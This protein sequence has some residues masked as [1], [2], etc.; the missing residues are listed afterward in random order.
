MIRH[1]EASAILS[2]GKARSRSF[3]RAISCHRTATALMGG[4]A[5]TILL[6]VPAAAQTTHGGRGGQGNAPGSPAG[7]ISS[8]TGAGSTGGNAAENYEGAGGG[9]AGVTGGAG[10]N[11]FNGTLGGAGG[12]TAGA[13]GS[14][15]VGGGIGSRASG[16][17]GGAHGAVLSGAPGTAVT[18][19]NGG[20]GGYG[21]F[22]G[23]SGGDGGIGLLLTGTGTTASISGAVTGGNGGAGGI[24]VASGCCSNGDNGAGGIGLIGSGVAIVLHATITGGLNGNGVTRAAAM[25]LSGTNQIALASGWGL[26]GG[27]ELA[28]GS[29]EFVQGNNQTLSNDIFGSGQLIKSSIGNLTLSGN[30]SYAG[31]T[32]IRGG[33]LTM[34]SANALG[35]GD[36]LLSGGTLDLFAYDLAAGRVSGSGTITSS[37]G[38]TLTQTSG[39]GI[40]GSFG[41][42]IV[43]AVGI[44]VD[45]GATLTLRGNNNL[46]GGIVLAG[47]LVIDQT[48]A[49]GGSGN[50]ITTVGSVIS[51]ANGVDNTANIQIASD[52]TVLDV[53]GGD[54]ATQSGVISEDQPGRGFEKSGAGILI[55]SATNSYTGTTLVSGGVLGLAANGAA[56][57]GRIDL[58]NGTTLYNANPCGCATTIGNDIAIALG[59]TAAIATFGNPTLLSGTLSGGNLLFA[60]N[61]GAS[62][63]T[64]TGSNSYGATGIDQFIQLQVGDGGTAGTLGTGAVTVDGGLIFSRSDIVTV[65]NDIGGIG[66]LTQDGSGTLILTGSNNYSGGTTI[67]QG[68]LQVGAGGTIGTLGTG[69]IDNSGSLVFNRSDDLAVADYITG[70]GSITKLGAGTL[71]LSGTNDYTGITSILAGTLAITGDALGDSATV[72]IDN[73]AGITLLADSN[74]SHDMTILSGGGTID[75]DAYTFTVSGAVDFQGELTKLGAGTLTLRDENDAGTGAGGINV[76]AGTLALGSDTAAGTGTIKLADSTILLNASCGCNPLTVSNAIQIALGGTAT[77]DAD[78]YETVLSGSLTGG[79]LI[80]ADTFGGGTTTLTGTNSYGD[81]TVQANATLVIGDG[82]TTGTLGTGTVTTDGMLAFDRSDDITLSNAIG[83]SGLLGQFGTGK[84]ILT[85]T[86]TYSGG[87]LIL[88]PAGTIQVGDGGTSGALGTGQISMAGTLIFNRSDDI[89]IADDI[90]GDGTITKLGAGTLTLSGDNSSYAGLV[91][92]LAGTVATTQTGLGFGSIEIDNGAQLKALDDVNALNLTVLSGGA[93]IDT[94][95]HF[96]ALLGDLDFQGAFTKTGSGMLVLVNAFGSSTGSG[97]I[98]VDQGTLALVSDGAAG[99]GIIKLANGTTLQNASCG[100][101]DLNVDNA[102]QIALGGTATIDGADANVNLNGAIS[103]GD[104]HFINSVSTPAF[105]SAFQLNGTNSYGR[106]LIGP[107][108]AVI[109]YDGTLGA[110]DVVF[111]AAPSDPA[112][113]AALVFQNATDYSYAGKIIGSGIVSV[114]ADAGNSVTLT[115]SN[116]GSAN[117]TGSVE[118]MSGRL[119]INGDF[120]DVV[121]NT[122]TLLLEDSCFCGGPTAVLGGSGTFHG[123]VTM[124]EAVLAPGNSP[125]TLVIAG[126]LTLGS[127]TIL[128]YE[129]GEPGTPGGA[130]NDLVTVGGNLTLNG[131]LNTI[132]SGAGYGPGYYR[133]FNYGGTLTDNEIVIGSIAGGL[134]AQILT[135][136]GGQVNVR[137]GGAS[138]LQYWDGTDMGT[139]TGVTGGSG[140]WKGSNTN[141]T[142]PTGYAINDSWEGQTAVFAGAAGGTVTVFGT[143]NFEELRFETDGYVLSPFDSSARLNTTGGFSIIDVASGITADIGV[144]IQGGAGIDKTGTGT[145]ILSAA[146]AYSGATD[147]A[148]GTLRLGINNALTDPT[149]LTVWSGATLDLNGFTTHVGSLAGTGAV[150]LGNGR[151]DVGYNNSSTIFGGTVTGADGGTS[152]FTKNGSGT[153]TVDGTISLGNGGGVLSSFFQVNAGTLQVSGTGSL[154][155]DLIQNFSTIENSGTINA[156]SNFQTFSTVTNTATGVIT[157]NVQNFSTFDN[158]GTMDGLQS[159]GGTATNYATGVINGNVQTFA[160]FTSAGVINGSISNF[161]TALIENQVNGEIGNFQ[162]GATVTLTGTTTGITNYQ[163]TQDTLFDLAGFDTTIGAL[164]GGGSVQMGVATL[165]IDS[166][167]L[168]SSFGGTISGSGGLI[169]TG[170]GE[171]TLAGLNTYTGDTAVNAGTLTLDATGGLTSDVIVASGAT[172][173]DN[174]AVAG[175]VTNNGLLNLGGSS[176]VT[177]GL[178]WALSNNSGGVAHAAGTIDAGIQNAGSFVIDGAFTGVTRFDQSASGQLSLNYDFGVEA[179]T[180]S[181]TVDTGFYTLS[182]GNGGVSSAFDGV[183]SG[184]GGLTKTGTGTFT[185]TAD[186]SYTGQT[187]VND[188]TLTLI[189][190]GAITGQV[191]NYANFESA[192]TLRGGL[193]NDGG[194]TAL[195]RGRADGLIENHGDITLSGASAGNGIF[196]QASGGTFDL[197]GFNATFGALDGAGTIDLGAGYLFVGD[198]DGDTNFAGSI[199]GT[200]GFTKAGAGTMTLS[201]AS[202]YGGFTQITG[203]TLLLADG[204][205]IGTGTVYNNATLAFDGATDRSFGN[206]I[207]GYGSVIKTGTGLVTF[208]GTNNL[209][210]GEFSVQGGSLGFDNSQALGI[211]SIWLADSTR[212][213]NVEGSSTVVLANFIEIDGGGM[214]TLQ[215]VNGS[216]TIFNGAIGGGTARFGLSGGGATAFTLGTVNSYGDTRIGGG[217]A[218]TVDGGG[219]LGTGNTLFEAS[220]VPSSLTFANGINYGYGGT[221]SGSG[222]IVVDTAAPGVS[223]TLTGSNTAVDNFTGTV[224]VDT[225]RLVLNGDFGDVTNNSASLTL[226]GGSLGGSGMFHG[227]VTFGNAALNPGNSPGTLNIAGNLTL[228]AGTILNYELGEAGTVG[229]ANNDLVNVGGNLTLDGTLNVIPQSGFGEGYYRLFNYGGTFTDNGLNMGGL[230]GGYTPTLLTN[231]AGQVNILFSSSPQAIQ[232][233]DGSDMTGSSAASGGDGG[234]GVWS[235]TNTNWTAPTGYGVNDSWRGQVAVFGGAS[236]GTVT[237]QGTQAFQELRFTTDGYTIAGATATDGL[238]TTGGFSVVDVSNGVNATIAA[239]ISGAGGLT[240]TGTGTLSLGGVNSYTGDTTVSGGTLVLTASGSLAGAVVNDAVFNNA[241]TVAGLVTNN[242]VMTS[243]GTLNGGLDNG[244]NAS[245]SGVLNG[246]VT[247]ATGGTI[248]LTGATTGTGTVTQA[249]GG[250]IALNGFNASFDGLAGAGT[251]TLGSGRLTVGIGNGSTTFSGV[252]SGSGGLTVGRVGVGG[253]TLTLTGANTYTGNTSVDSG[254]LKLSATGSIAG[255]VGVSTTFDNAGTVAG[256]VSNNGAFVNTGTVSGRVYNYATAWIS[257]TV[258][259]GIVNYFGLDISGGANIVGGVSQW[260]TGSMSVSGDAYIGGLSGEG[261]VTLY[262]GTLTLGGSGQFFGSITGTGGVTST[263]SQQLNGASYTGLTTVASGGLSLTGTVTGDARVFNQAAFGSYATI[264]GNVL[265]QGSFAQNGIVTGMVQ[266]DGTLTN[267]GTITGGLLNNGTA[268]LSGVIGTGI[269]NNGAISFDG[270]ATTTVAALQQAA[271]GTSTFNLASF[272]VSIGAIAGSGAINLGGGALSIG[273]GGGNSVFAGT[274]SGAGSLIKTGTGTLALTGAATQTGGTTISGGTLQIGTGGTTGSLSGAIVNNGVLAINRSDAVTLGNIMSGTG[275]FV[276]AGTGTTTLTGANTYSGGTLVSAGRLRGDTGSLQGAI[277]IDG[278]LEFAQTGA[279]TYAGSLSGAGTFEKTGVGMLALTGNSSTFT[280]AT[281]VIAGQMA[282]NGLLSHSTVTVSNGATV[283]GTGTVGGLVVQSGGT[284]APGNSVGTFNVAGNVLFQAGSLFAAEIQGNSADKIQATGTAQLNGTLQVISLGGNYGINSTFVLLHADGGVSG[285]FATT[286]L[287]S[288][289]LAY[290]PKIIYTANEVQLFLAPNQL[291]AVLG[292]GVPLT[293]NQAST[294]GRIDAAVMTGGYD[295][296]ALSALYSLAPAAIP[297]AL[298]Q[299][300]GEIYADATR[301]ALE[302]ERVVREAVIGRLAEA[303]DQGVSGN[304]AWGQVIGSWGSVDSDGNAAGY[305]VNRTGMLMGLD[306]GGA[307][308]DGSWRAGVMGHYTRIIVPAD[309]RGSRATIDRTG[310]GFYAGA[311]I[312][313]LRVRTGATLSLLDLK[314]RRNIAIPGLTTTERGKVQGVMFQTFGEVSYRIETGTHGFVEP[315]LAGSATRVSFGRFAES[316]GP[317]ALMVRTQKSVLGIAELGLRGEMGLGTSAIRLGGNIGLRT[318]FGD[319]TANPIIALTAAPNQAFNVHSA[320]IDRFA[321]AAN[322][323]LTADLSD[324]LSLRIGYTGMMGSGAREHGGRATLSLKF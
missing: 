177:S 274:I 3:R 91:S 46:T 322:L 4:L 124:G 193:Y 19:G 73:G 199:T 30:N 280:G 137:L 103:G 291:S 49:A 101:Y 105:G 129:L 151:L 141:W 120:G 235:G 115:G 311:A 146:N 319:R 276:Q 44:S 117:F 295:P 182:V 168:Y 107:N 185:L 299:L 306:A 16:G 7:G 65:S 18:G 119:V 256:D 113:P 259:G 82:G 251:I 56:G 313:G 149:A 293:Y 34:G 25:Q 225:G 10:G 77:I 213:R 255:S 88:N 42:G 292:N 132:A 236:G 134:D 187:T 35:S 217:V 135:N 74:Q 29:L 26:V 231:I 271:T 223:V 139:T 51:Y 147:I 75:T 318:A 170:A 298:D 220:G 127:G 233:W 87:T 278:A 41:G 270:S 32:E 86:N 50:T 123:S 81:T 246:A 203:G 2:M 61:F 323:N 165:T 304:G 167:R 210:A 196:E 58:G 9:G 248:T 78:G 85:G 267:R 316:S 175:Y 230:P 296:V 228:G 252:I 266:N 89:A 60:S 279:G 180:G 150:T 95:S 249:A 212:L 301:A 106:T 227:D 198:N 172:F 224:T 92:I 64:L 320:E 186:S 234:A 263:G 239:P 245:I 125:G 48:G 211:G 100:C 261:T 128:N 28:G 72:E 145:L 242:S 317:V 13:S 12:A 31:G 153:L 159:L 155:A 238:A 109:V 204:G 99:A 140:N 207:V 284:I 181:G 154:S 282:I 286:N 257:G 94:G 102:I 205:A 285:T 297:A 33:T 201:G 222:S 17:G 215:G 189:Y 190:S 142:G 122:A 23:G 47:N 126:N 76:L 277:K 240:K 221:I 241:G 183:I 206:T 288:F 68:I 253:Y 290:R 93:T 54:S 97:D 1:T 37:A 79:N 130:N 188:G 114:E 218:L 269:V 216:N 195:L 43:S 71:T 138:A 116:T 314:A 55:L 307:S 237:V 194:A 164:N 158:Y 52:T 309:T 294:I 160:N 208:T 258:T 6:A 144:V 310:G 178:L 174:G 83:G 36:I 118:V 20:N 184:G 262:G 281:N 67:S 96:I 200:G 45:A 265:N 70:S 312:G 232:Y 173:N 273:A 22:Y 104:V 5:A 111:D 166:G 62:R 275:G 110:G 179:L 272:G 53:A 57:T 287:A 66:S 80:F 302:D 176:T 108:T 162:V 202:N 161:S 163:G 191:N 69:T 192:G 308:D 300:S 148:A 226:N 39:T 133:L 90:A 27:I 21:Y 209:F 121:G 14:D 260:D 156:Y 11:A 8:G 303:A 250:S 112:L 214:A 264:I 24:F 169:K 289:G 98:N 15:G 152:T 38:A 197:A 171:Q 324:A 84:L 283:G 143:Q 243:T 315:Y 254:W 131:T 136:I 321:A 63:I 244:G 40:F 59:G 229:G 305:D 157:G 247:N 219:T 268:T